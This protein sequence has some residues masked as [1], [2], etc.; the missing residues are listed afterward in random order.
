MKRVYL[1]RHA[2]SS[3]SDPGLDDFHRPLNNRGKKDGPAMA[4]RL[5]AAGVRPDLIVSSPAVRAKKTAGFMAE[6]TGYHQDAIQFDNNLYLGSFSYYC[7]LIA[8]LLEKI[9][10]LFLVGHNGTITE[11]AEHLCGCSLGNVPTCGVVAL[12]YSDEGGFSDTAGRGKLT[13]FW[14]P[15]DGGGARK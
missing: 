3:W 8:T 7:R 14:Y 15:K 6:A 12:D 10:V 2:K 1:I 4:N 11:L 13:F 5:C 9:D